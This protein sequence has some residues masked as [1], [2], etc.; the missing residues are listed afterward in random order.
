MASARSFEQMMSG[1]SG[2]CSTRSSNQRQDVSR[3][4]DGVDARSSGES[5]APQRAETARAFPGND[6]DGGRCC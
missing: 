5:S 4:R 2:H 3:S 1:K 6:E